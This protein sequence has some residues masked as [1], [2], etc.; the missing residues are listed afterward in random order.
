MA[1]D[2]P[3]IF[4][5]GPI[6]DRWTV[7]TSDAPEGWENGYAASAEGETVATA[8]T[9]RTLVSRLRDAY[10]VGRRDREITYRG[11]DV[12]A[13]GA[14]TIHVL[15]EDPECRRLV[16]CTAAQDITAI[17]F[18]ERAGYRYVTDVDLADGGSVSLMV[19]EPVSVLSEPNAVESHR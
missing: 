1:E 12:E 18:A 17:D 13:L 3:G 5:P 15:T 2:L 10:P 14:I 6:P 11:E 16:L 8:A 4:H 7:T 19:A 9:R